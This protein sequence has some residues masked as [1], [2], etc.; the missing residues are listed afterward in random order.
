MKWPFTKVPGIAAQGQPVHIN[1][2]P[3][4]TARVLRVLH[5]MIRLIEHQA[6]PHLPAVVIEEAAQE[7][8]RSRRLL[9]AQGINIPSDRTGIEALIAEVEKQRAAR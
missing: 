3:A 8:N 4:S 5:R 2:E 9:A 6:K 1:L 7:F